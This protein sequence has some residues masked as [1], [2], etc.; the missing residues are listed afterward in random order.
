[1]LASRV[2]GV[3]AKAK[4]KES[5]Y[6]GSSTITIELDIPVLLKFIAGPK[7]AL[8]GAAE[9]SKV[10][11]GEFKIVEFICNIVLGIVVP[12]PTRPRL[13]TVNPLTPAPAGLMKTFKGVPVVE[14]FRRPRKTEPGSV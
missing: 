12:I 4:D 3:F 14:F 1:M 9:V 6:P 8:F 7:V 13:V 2:N 10:N 5:P 11:H